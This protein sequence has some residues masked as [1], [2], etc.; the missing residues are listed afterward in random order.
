MVT[1][2]IDTLFARSVFIANLEQRRMSK[3]DK[4][5][6]L[7]R[8]LLTVV[9]A[10]LLM[11]GAIAADDEREERGKFPESSAANSHPM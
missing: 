6:F 1:I 10:S 4:A 2:G 7:R 3:R 9:L 5:P 8:V 11:I